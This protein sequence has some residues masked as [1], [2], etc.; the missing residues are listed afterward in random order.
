M[1]K[2]ILLVA[3]LAAS[4]TLHAELAFSG[5][6]AQIHD[7]DALRLNPALAAWQ[8][9]SFQ[10]DWQAMHMGLAD[11]PAA[12]GQGGFAFTL[13][14]WN[15]AMQAQMRDTDL[16]QEAEVALQWAWQPLTGFALGVE[17]GMYRFGWNTSVLHGDLGADPVFRDGS[18]RVQPTVGIGCFYAPLPGLHLALA[19]RH[20]NRPSLS[21][22]GSDT[23]APIRSFLGAEWRGREVAF[24]VALD[25]L[26]YLEADGSAGAEMVSELSPSLY[27]D[28]YLLP[29]L[30]A[31]VRYRHE[32]LSLSC[33]YVFERMHKV[34]YEYSMPLGDLADQSV[35]S[36]RISYRVSLGDWLLPSGVQRQAVSRG[37]L[38]NLFGRRTR[39]FETPLLAGLRDNSLE[40]VEL[41]LHLPDSLAQQIPLESLLA[42]QLER[43]RTLTPEGGELVRGTYSAE[44][45]RLAGLLESLQQERGVIPVIHAG[46]NTVRIE[47]VAALAGTTVDARVGGL[48]ELP[49]SGA[50]VPVP[51]SLQIELSLP[52]DLAEQ[53]ASWVILLS[54][55]HGFNLR[56][57]GQGVPP[58]SI[59]LPV[60]DTSGSL[61]ALGTAHVEIQLLDDH[62][63]VLALR[64]LELQVLKRVRHAWL[65]P[66][67][68]GD[69][70][71]AGT[72]G[73][74]ILLGD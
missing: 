51:D 70:A 42:A 30:E 9:L 4:Q 31:G 38:A 60:R 72:D 41:H 58:A 63:S 50:L 56:L 43:G 16:L 37:S 5:N 18:S 65:R 20:L 7:N 28:S 74:H 23:R 54:A 15:L 3:L 17:A 36:H 61:P 68:A 8:P 53:C 52:E 67:E 47:D 44:Y 25:N 62:T 40:L 55:E 35:G 66:L 2:T 45:F 22:S 71:P 33:A 57:E 19:L 21:L 59:R 64:Q 39:A 32:A 34:S 49:P 26:D 12:F 1:R 73:I 10:A 69:P 11:S 14:R 13:P 24:G 46:E 6:P 27:L 48:S 29:N